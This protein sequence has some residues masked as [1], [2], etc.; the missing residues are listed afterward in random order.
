VIFSRETR[1]KSIRKFVSRMAL[2][3]GLFGVAFLATPAWSH[4]PDETHT[5][6]EQQDSGTKHGSLGAVGSKLS[7][8]TANIWALQASISALEFFDG[9]ANSGESELG[10]GVTF[11]PVMPFPLYGTGDDEWKLVTRP[12]IP[13]IFSQPVPAPTT[14]TP[15][16]LNFDH[17]SGIGDIQIPFLVNPS[18]SLMGKN[19]IFGLGPVFEFPTSTKDALG[20]QQFAMGPA[21]V[22][23]YKRAGVTAVLFPNYFWKIG[24]RSDK[25]SLTPATSKLSLLYSLNISL[26]NAWQV[27]FNPTISYNDKAATN[28]NKWTV[29]VGLYAGRTIKVGPMPVNI[30]LGVEYSVVSPDSFGKRA[31]LRL[32][33]TPVIPGLVKKPILG[34]K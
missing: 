6:M 25:S 22:V 28:G 26:P 15:P 27:G 20:K 29:P 7:D 3:A 31:V 32:Q 33:V 16:E 8:P 30:K 18:D 10:G 19:I 17:K 24:S 34:G 11:Q 5:H 12:V 14:S 23:G 13:I 9:D 2:V 4:P 21:L 1:F